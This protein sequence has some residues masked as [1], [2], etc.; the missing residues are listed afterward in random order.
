MVKRAGNFNG[1]LN[2]ADDTAVYDKEKN[3]ETIK[4]ISIRDHMA[5][6]ICLFE[7]L[8]LYYKYD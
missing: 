2:E 8:L 3:M 7:R 6:V 4:E 5:Y 1:Y